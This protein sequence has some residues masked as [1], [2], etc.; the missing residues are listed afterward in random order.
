MFSFFESQNGSM[1]SFAFAWPEILLCT[2]APSEKP[3]LPTQ[4]SLQFST[5]SILYISQL[6]AE[7]GSIFV[8]YL[9]TL[10][11]YHKDDS[12]KNYSKSCSLND[13]KQL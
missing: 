8:Q 1:G 5:V 2:T 12:H 7:S 9:T 6:L 4:H 10:N 13:Q 11:M 3:P